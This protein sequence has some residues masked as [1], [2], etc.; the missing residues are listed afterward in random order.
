M[1]RHAPLFT[2]I[3][4]LAT[5][6]MGCSNAAPPSA[7]SPRTA[8][9]PIAGPLAQASPVAA[10]S[11][12][13]RTAPP[14]PKKGE[15]ADS[16]GLRELVREPTSWRSPLVNG[17]MP[18]AAVTR[19]KILGFNDFHGQLMGRT[20]EGR[21]VGGAAVLASYLKEAARGMEDA[22]V[23]AHA[24]D[25][26]GAS[27]PESAFYQD[28]PSIAFANLLANAACSGSKRTD[29]HCNVVFTIGNHEFDEGSSEL[30]RLLKGGNHPKGPFLGA[31]YRGPTFPF[32]VSNVV[33]AATGNAILPPYVVKELRGVRVGFIGAVLRGSPAFLIGSGIREV[34]FEDEASHINRNVME[35]KEQGV[36]AVVV[37]IH[38]GG[39]QVFEPGF[40]RDQSAVVGPIV[41][42]VRRLDAEVDVVVTGHTHSV[43]N[44]L[45]PNAG[46]RPTLV[47]QAFH[48]STAFADIDLEIDSKS[49]DVTAKTARILSTFGDQAPGIDPDAQVQALVT[50]I[51]RS[52]E[53]Q[54]S[55]IIAQGKAELTRKLDRA[56]QSTLGNVLAEAQRTVTGSDLAFI[57]PAWLRADLPQGPVSYGQ[58]FAAQPFGNRL[59][60][61]ELTGTQVRELLNQQWLDESYNRVL[62]VSGLSYSWDGRRPV[63]SRVVEISVGGAP[64]DL[65]RKYS[66][67]VNEFLA[68]GGEGYSVLSGVAKSD[69]G[70]GDLEALVRWAKR[71]PDLQSAEGNRILRLD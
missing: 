25:F 19:V 7:S 41:D 11:G 2:A 63:T 67:T 14:S 62:C 47:T 18:G 27:P 36:H 69:A 24:G 34:R 66:V 9:Q 3:I 71:H 17:E 10:A 30:L 50:Q 5:S 54:T 33:D 13:G 43:L 12:E 64:L 28:E 60:K 16:I 4:A 20:L 39:N 6:E 49:G 46:G 42:I 40:P 35:L 32:V 21:P 70:V 59:L 51:H 22:T 29:P 15:E 65:A 1:R 55:Q 53:R 31:D 48:A 45:L 52:V 58:L 57:T 38:Q 56:G 23:I 26:I 68:E 61:L 37:V 44:A 8:L